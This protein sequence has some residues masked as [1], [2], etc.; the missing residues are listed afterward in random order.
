M[1]TNSSPAPKHPQEQTS[2][3]FMQSTTARVIMVGLLTLALLIPLQY[4][5]GIINERQHLQ[6]EVK[7]D[8][9][10]KWGGSVYVLGPV[11]KLPYNIVNET[12]VVDKATKKITIRRSISTDY[13]YIFPEQLDIS[14][15]VKTT[16]KHR[17][18]Y[19]A[20]VF[21]SDMKLK[22]FYPAPD[23]AKHNIAAE[24]VRWDKASVIMST[25]TLKSIKGA[26]NISVKGN[27]Y[28]FEPLAKLTENESLSTLQTTN[29]NLNGA[30]TGTLPFEMKISYDG[31]EQLGIVPVGKYTTAKMN[32]NWPSPK[33]DGNFLPGD[34][35]VTDAGFNA[36][37]KISQLNRPFA[38]QYITTIPDLSKYTFDVDFFIPV[39]EYQQNERASKYGFLVIGLTFLIFFLIQSI[40][41]IVIHIFQYAMIGLALI[42]FYTL[43]ISITEHSS[44]KLAYLIAGLSVVV[45]VAL[46][47]V[48]ILKDKRFPLFIGASLAALYTFIYVII[49]LENYA[50]LAGSIGLFFILGAVMYFSRKINWS[51]SPA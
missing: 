4:V 5:K 29:I 14:T 44:F 8:I 26:V 40:S 36:S 39:D 46:Y 13:L 47:S 41:K 37:W 24:N 51:S 33:F 49:Q 6:E 2:F 7:N 15:A 11:L 12:E 28:N 35:T 22:G 38:Q 17:S 31:S 21:T 3:S 34:S 1:E 9:S 30:I 16:K 32:G 42:M 19:E 23:L 43:L 48:S 10:Q 25:N 50:L 27:K 18:N 45:M 20:A